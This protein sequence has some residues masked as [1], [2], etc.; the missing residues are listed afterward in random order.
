MRTG[1]FAGNTCHELKI[2]EKIGL[3]ESAAVKAGGGPRANAEPLVSQHRA[4]DYGDRLLL[5]GTATPT[6]SPTAASER[7]CER[8]EG[9]LSG[10][11]V[12]SRC[13]PVAV[14]RDRQLWRSV[15]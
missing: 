11:V 14:A 13:R 4:P 9:Q 7:P 12:N 3:T 1:R 6:C 8:R 2:A 15:A 10:S 5:A